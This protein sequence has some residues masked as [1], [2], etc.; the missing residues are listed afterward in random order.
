MMDNKL[1][2]IIEELQNDLDLS[3]DIQEKDWLKHS[4][5][6]YIHS[7]VWSDNKLLDG[8]YTN[9]I[10]PIISNVIENKAEIINKFV[11]AVIEQTMR[12]M[13]ANEVA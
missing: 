12:E 8:F 9:E 2:E 10:E 7:R 5:K 3:S 6:T 1:A 4:L 13:F 11:G